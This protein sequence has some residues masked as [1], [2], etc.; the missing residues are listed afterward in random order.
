M[1][2]KTLKNT[3][4]SIGRGVFVECFSI[5]ESYANSQISRDDCIEKLT[6]KYPNKEESGC[7]ICC[8]KAK[9]IF[10]EN[11]QCEAIDIICGNWGQTKLSDETI[12][13]AMLLLQ[14]CS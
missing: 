8:N 11:M 2:E 3:L 5:F 4:N 1:N 6:Q 7:K 14:D 9:S 12:E 10:E 13:K